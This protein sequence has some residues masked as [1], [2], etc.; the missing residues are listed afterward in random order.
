MVSSRSR[1]RRRLVLPPAP[2]WSAT[3]AG[4]PLNLK[5]PHD[6]PSSRPRPFD[7]AFA[8][9]G[10][11]STARMTAAART[12]IRIFRWSSPA[13]S[14]NSAPN[15]MAYGQGRPETFARRSPSLPRRRTADQPYPEAPAG[16]PRLGR[17]SA[18][19]SVFSGARTEL[20]GRRHLFRGARRNGARSG[21]RGAG[22]PQP[23]RNPAYP[24]SVCGVVYQNKDWRN[25][26]QFSFACDG[27]R[28]RVSIPSTGSSP[29][30]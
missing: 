2:C 25:R 14:M 17:Q 21:G 7:Q 13:S 15:L 30:Q 23:R 6:W 16:R 5:T 29:R 12:P 11:R 8:S 9:R 20:P 3:A 27:I 28:D 26:C 22:H 24:N 18:A 4:R 10:S 1:R 19:A